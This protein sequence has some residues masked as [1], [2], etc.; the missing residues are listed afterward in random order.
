MGFNPG[1]RSSHPPHPP[2]LALVALAAAE[3]GPVSGKGLAGK[4]AVVTGGAWK[5]SPGTVYPLLQ[6]MEKGG[7]LKCSV[8]PTEGRG[9]RELDYSLTARGKAFL[10][11]AREKS[12]EYSVMMIERMVPLTAFVCFGEEDQE[13]L[14]LV[15]RV[16]REMNEKIWEKARL[17]KETRLK[18]LGKL[19]GIIRGM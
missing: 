18:K 1:L 16:R 3:K 19:L 2:M 13:T 7:L 6:R 12:K 17:P 11:R 9:R 8:A 5:L 4:V 15:K 14:A 10:A